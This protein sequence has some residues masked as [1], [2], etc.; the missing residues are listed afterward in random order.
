MTL[1]KAGRPTPKR[2]RPAVSLFKALRGASVWVRRV[3]AFSFSAMLNRKSIKKK[4]A[5]H[6]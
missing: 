3:R 4:D 1:N 6:D 2:A 5:E